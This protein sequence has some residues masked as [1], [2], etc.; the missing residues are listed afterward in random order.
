MRRWA[1]AGYAEEG[2]FVATGGE[3]RRRRNGCDDC[4]NGPYLGCDGA[5]DG[6]LRVV[7]ASGSRDVDNNKLEAVLG[8]NRRSPPVISM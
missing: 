6:V 8:R 3:M 4:W 5:L 1:L 7:K 2:V